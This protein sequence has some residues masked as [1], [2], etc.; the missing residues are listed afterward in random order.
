MNFDQVRGDGFRPPDFGNA[1]EMKEI[2]QKQQAQLA[3]LEARLK[4]SPPAQT[5]FGIF[6][7]PP[8]GLKSLPNAPN[9]CLVF[10]AIKQ[11][12]ML[13]IVRG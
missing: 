12:R 8:S 6:K 11:R 2:L 13:P 7:I 9:I 1:D 10:W 3:E 5:H 4:L